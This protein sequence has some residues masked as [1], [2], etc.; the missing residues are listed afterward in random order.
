MAVE[1]SRISRRQCLL[2]TLGAAA[3]PAEAS[4]NTASEW[5]Q[6]KA[7]IRKRY[8][9]VPQLTV[10]DLVAWLHDPQRMPP[11]LLD[12]RSAAEFSDGHLAGAVR[13]ETLAQAQA[14]LLNA[15]N[16]R[17]VVLYCAVGMRSSKLAAELVALGRTNVFNLEGSAFEWANT[18]HPLV[19]DRQ[20]TDKTHPYDK[21]WGRYLDR[22]HWSRQ[23]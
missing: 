22:D 9:S 3:W 19:N 4:D 10:P 5:L 17:P 20:A 6:L 18:G 23:P 1:T 21:K 13:A 12:V 15:A 7:R 16:D 14:A 2:W 11:V 8:P